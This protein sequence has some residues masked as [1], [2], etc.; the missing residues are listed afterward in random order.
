MDIC[1]SSVVPSG[2]D[3][4]ASGSGY[5]DATA[6]QQLW[7]RVC[8]CTSALYAAYHVPVVWTFLPPALCVAAYL[9]LVA[10]GVLLQLLVDRFGLVLAILVH[11]A[12]DL[13][14]SLLV[15]DI[16]FAWGIL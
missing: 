7:W 6:D 2:G 14:A 11:A 5:P 1:S 15:A 9:G 8:L 13:T 12:Y 4:N 16:I 3:A 10:L